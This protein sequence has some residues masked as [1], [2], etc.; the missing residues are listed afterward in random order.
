MASYARYVALGDSQTE[1]L[2]DG[3]DT[4]G[5]RGFADRL[6][7][8]LDALSPR[9]STPTWPYAATRSAMCSTC[10]CPTLWRWART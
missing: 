8:M 2:W 7:E 6:A 1:G 9:C 10:S 3:D 4:S 5:L